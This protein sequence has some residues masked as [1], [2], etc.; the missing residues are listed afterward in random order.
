MNTDTFFV[1]SRTHRVTQDYTRAGRVLRHSYAIVSDGCSSSPDTDIGARLLTLE[2]ARAIA[3]FPEKFSPEEIVHKA[4]ALVSHPLVQQ[5]LD[6][7][8]LIARETPVGVEVHVAGDGFVVA[9]RQED[10][11]RLFVFEFDFGSAP[12]YLSYLLDPLRREA[13]LQQGYGKRTIRTWSLLPNQSPSLIGIH[14]DNPFTGEADY[15]ADSVGPFHTRTFSKEEY[16]LVV[17]CTDGAGAFQHKDT[18]E[19]IPF[20]QVLR[21]LSYFPSF[22]GEFVTRR[23]RKFVTKECLE[24][25][26]VQNDDLG[27]GAIYMGAESR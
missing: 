13:Y 21:H 1:G 10:K 27:V 6:A 4:A 3:R 16:D 12:A 15:P 18:L 19:S 11:Q 22:T 14:S 20:H 7:T 25:G 17:V 5:C 26:W 24:L 9:R 2:A 8:L 23:V